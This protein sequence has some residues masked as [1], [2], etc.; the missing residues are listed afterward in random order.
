[1][2][3]LL[4]RTSPH[5]HRPPASTPGVPMG[6]PG[7]FP[8]GQNDS[9]RVLQR[10]PSGAPPVRQAVHLLPEESPRVSGVGRTRSPRAHKPADRERGRVHEIG[11]QAARARYEASA[12]S[13][14]RPA[15]ELPCAALRGQAPEC[16]LVFL[17]NRR[18]MRLPKATVRVS[19]SRIS[20]TCR[21]RSKFDF[22]ACRGIAIDVQL[23]SRPTE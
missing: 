18:S 3:T 10:R 7:R 12:V 22:P 6:L 16:T 13:F 8:S 15:N 17:R 2:I 9:Y 4:M 5:A 19:V 23:D 21:A 20:R 11:V 1:M 14:R